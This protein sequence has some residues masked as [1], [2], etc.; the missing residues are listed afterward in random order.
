[1]MPPPR[2][3]YVDGRPAARLRMPADDHGPVLRHGPAAFDHLAARDVVVFQHDGHYFMHYDAAGPDGWV[4]A[5]ATSDDGLGWCKRGPILELGRDGDPDRGSASYGVPVF[6]G[7]RW[8][9]FYLGTPH[10]SGPPERIPA[11][12]YLTRKAIADT[13]TGRWVKQPDLDPL[14]PLAGSWYEHTVAPGQIRKSDHG[15]FQ[16]FSAARKDGDSIKRTLGYATTTDLDARWRIAPQPILPVDEQVEN[17][18]LYHEPANGLWFLFTNHVAIHDDPAFVLPPEHTAE[19]TARSGS[20][21]PT[22]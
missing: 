11:F 5:L 13:P 3:S 17:S 22:T 21:G 6:D 2:P 4:A 19:Y 12:P 20:T 7:H 10:T 14:P 15:W 1:M 18:S 9:L 16:F 8:H